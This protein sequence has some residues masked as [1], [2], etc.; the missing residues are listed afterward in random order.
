MDEI[1][2]DETLIIDNLNN[3]VA[4][5]KDNEPSLRAHRR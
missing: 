3:Q 1:Y 5:T 4:K 2:Y